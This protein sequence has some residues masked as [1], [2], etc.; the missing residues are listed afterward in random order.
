MG[1]A[2]ST[3]GVLNMWTWLLLWYLQTQRRGQDK[4]AMMT[5]RPPCWGMWGT[6]LCRYLSIPLCALHPAQAVSCFCAF[7]Q[8]RTPVQKAISPLDLLE[9]SYS[10]FKTPFRPQDLWEASLDMLS[11]PIPALR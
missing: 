6:E 9:N 8:T 4:P 1:K 11:S 7:A 10:S 3:W 2:L 5:F